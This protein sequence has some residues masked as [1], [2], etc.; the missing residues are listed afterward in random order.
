M[1]K[2]SR[3]SDDLLPLPKKSPKREGSPYDLNT[4]PIKISG[5][6]GGMSP[7]AK[8]T[9]K[10]QKVIG[11]LQNELAGLKKGKKTDKKVKEK[12]HS[13]FDDIL[14]PTPK[15]K[16]I[17][18]SQGD[19]E[20]LLDAFTPS[21]L[22]KKGLK[23]K[24]KNDSL[25]ILDEFITVK[26]IKPKSKEQLD[27]EASFRAFYKEEVIDIAKRCRKIIER[28]N[29]QGSYKL[30]EIIGVQVAKSSFVKNPSDAKMILEVS[31]ARKDSFFEN[32]MSDGDV[33][34]D[35][36][37]VRQATILMSSDVIRVV[38]KLT[39]WVE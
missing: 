13:F 8:N 26:E 34:P 39:A 27:E 5:L 4:S 21:V 14:P 2:K 31:P 10:L 12:K 7:L 33:L 24:V 6:K 16:K 36:Q 20:D 15:H 32:D 29:A 35:D 37:A 38:K 22:K 1:F 25:E 11:F 9:K 17:I 18:E 30:N 19:L 23:V 28:D 3:L